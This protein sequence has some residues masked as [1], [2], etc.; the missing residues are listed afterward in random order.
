MLPACSDINPDAVK[1]K[2]HDKWLYIASDLADSQLTFDDNAF[3]AISGL[4]KSFGTVLNDQ[5]VAGIWE[6]NLF[7]GLLWYCRRSHYPNEKETNRIGYVAPTWSWLAVK[8][9]I[10]FLARE[11]LA[12]YG[13]VVL[14]ADIKLVHVDHADRDS[15]GWLSGGFIRLMCHMRPCHERLAVRQSSRFA[16]EC[17]RFDGGYDDNGKQ[18]LDHLVFQLFQVKRPIHVGLEYNIHLGLRDS[19]LV[20]L[21]PCI[22]FG[23]KR[24][25]LISFELATVINLELNVLSNF[26][27]NILINFEHAT[28][29]LDIFSNFGLDIIINF[30]LCIFINLELATIINL[31]L[32]IVT[33]LELSVGID[34]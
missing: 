33:N 9:G 13:D 26:E 32:A 29:E 5:Y 19:I 24:Y 11:H 17:E 15:F 3:P 18:S 16:L 23:L 6:G 22:L 1:K 8:R 25:I 21:E 7:E 30:E 14:H 31:K 28:V 4:A 12:L 20:G 34:F 27:L 2:M 10:E